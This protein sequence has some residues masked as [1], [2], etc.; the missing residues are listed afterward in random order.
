MINCSIC[1]L[2]TSG[3]RLKLFFIF[4]VYSFYLALLSFCVCDH[5]GSV[6]GFVRSGYPLYYEAGFPMQDVKPRSSYSWYGADV[7][8]PISPQRSRSNTYSAAQVKGVYSSVS[9]SPQNGSS[10][11]GPVTN[12]YKPGSDSDASSQLQGSLISSTGSGSLVS[13]SVTTAIG[14]SMHI[15]S[16]PEPTQLNY[17][18]VVQSSNESVVSSSQQIVQNSSQ[19]SGQLPIVKPQSSRLQVVSKLFSGNRPV[20]I[21]SS[22]FLVKPLQ[23]KNDSSQPSYQLGQASFGSHYQSV[24]QP[25]SLQ[26]AQARYH[27][28]SQLSGLQSAQ[29]RYQ[30]VSQP[31]GLQAVPARYLS[32]SQPSGLQSAQSRLQ[33]AQARYQSVSQPSGLQAVQARYLSVSQPSGLQ[34]AQARYQSVSQPSSLQSAQSRL[35]SAQARYQSVSQPSSLQSAQACYQSVDP[36]S[37]LQSAQ[38]H[39]QSVSRPS[40]LQSAQAH[41]QSVSRQSRFQVFPKPEQSSYR[42]LSSLGSKPLELPTNIQLQAM[43]LMQ[44]VQP[45]F[46]DPAPLHSQTT[47]N[48]HLSPGILS[49]LHQVKS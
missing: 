2:L 25:S 16:L 6:G 41:Y 46:Q 13:G 8:N 14:A 45:G 42:S 4:F 38:A 35:Q 32:V 30:S 3:I 31:S 12:V 43:S 7:S 21:S 39:Y 5:F 26:S 37:G 40:S 33:S 17:Q 11:F 18:T 9:Y 34:A 29:S 19:S 44:S 47:Q 23:Q 36:L 10:G 1:C 15:E 24:S 49:L 48:K 28:V 22:T 20:Q 27:T